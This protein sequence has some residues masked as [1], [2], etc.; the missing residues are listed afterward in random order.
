VG[1]HPP[2]D[3]DE[4]VR[5]LRFPPGPS[6]LSRSPVKS[7]VSTARTAP[8]GS[9]KPVEGSVADSDP[10]PMIRYLQAPPNSKFSLEPIALGTAAGGGAES[11]QGGVERSFRGP[12]KR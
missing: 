6:R 11:V 7:P 8:V 1:D 9:A 3:Q 5:F 2:S 12:V 4:R 10:S